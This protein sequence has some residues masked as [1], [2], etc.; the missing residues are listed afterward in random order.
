[1]A[2]QNKMWRP[3]LQPAAA[4]CA[5]SFPAEHQQCAAHTLQLHLPTPCNTPSLLKHRFGI[6]RSA[7]TPSTGLCSLLYHA[8]DEQCLELPQLGLQHWAPTAHKKLLSRPSTS[9]RGSEQGE[10]GLA[11]LQALPLAFQGQ[12]KALSMT[13]VSPQPWGPALGVKIHPRE[14]CAVRVERMRMDAQL[15]FCRIFQTFW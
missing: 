13:H 15:T 3:W 12:Q 6:T 7:P 8:D 11:C 5:H 2:L 9:L 4:L 10:G 14:V 1:M